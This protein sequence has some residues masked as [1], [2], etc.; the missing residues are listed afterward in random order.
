MV[1]LQNEHLIAFTPYH[2]SIVISAGISHSIPFFNQLEYDWVGIP[3]WLSLYTGD[4]KH[5]FETGLGYWPALTYNRENV[6]YFTSRFEQ[7]ILL[8][9]GYRLQQSTRGGLVLKAGLEAGLSISESYERWVS[10]MLISPYVSA[11][12]SF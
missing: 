8:K 3:L 9:A 10:G 4:R 12:Y 5:H 7:L 6:D 11:G 2:N 1:S